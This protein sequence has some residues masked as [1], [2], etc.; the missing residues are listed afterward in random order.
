MRLGYRAG[1]SLVPRHRHGCQQPL[2]TEVLAVRLPLCGWSMARSAGTVAHEDVVTMSP[3]CSSENRGYPTY[4]AWRRQPN[5]SGSRLADRHGADHAPHR[6]C[7][8]QM[9]WQP[10]PLASTR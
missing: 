4:S 2:A 10:Q 1:Y 5:Y 3:L 8:G 9:A 7:S 6:R